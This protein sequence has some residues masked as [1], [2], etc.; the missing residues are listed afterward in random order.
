MPM[1]HANDSCHK[2]LPP[3]VPA[4]YTAVVPRG[5]LHHGAAVGGDLR[6]LA[7]QRALLIGGCGWSLGVEPLTMVI[8]GGCEWS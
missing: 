3:G 6:D 1:I 7:H 8:H 5:H 4:A 2:S